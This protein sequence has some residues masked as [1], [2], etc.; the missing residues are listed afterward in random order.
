MCGAGT[1]IT[2]NINGECVI[3]LAQIF[4]LL[5]HTTDFVVGIRHVRGEYICLFD[6]QF[7]LVGIQSFPP[8]K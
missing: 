8:G 6:E 1:V 5:D 7:L 4:D 2:T 3:Q